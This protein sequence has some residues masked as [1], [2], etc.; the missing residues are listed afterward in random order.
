MQYG[1]ALAISIFALSV[2]AADTIFSW[3]DA[4]G[5]VH[6]GDFPPESVN[7]K[8]VDLPELTV[9]KDYGK[10]YKS[11]LT[12]K[13]R[14]ITKKEENKKSPYTTF[15][16]LAPQNNQAIRANDGDVTVML[17]LK[18]KLLP[19][20]KLSIFL[21]GKQ[22]VEGDLRIVNLTN[23]DRGKHKV[24]AIIKDKKNKNISK[25]KEVVFTVIRH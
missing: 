24:H 22:I 20:H 25:S 4:K 15:S 21:N 3:K 16:I 9:V 7:A 1:I 8:P 5:V 6:Y 17:I 19:E 13:E 12:A 10:L 11:V 23:L 18:P 2:V 14:G